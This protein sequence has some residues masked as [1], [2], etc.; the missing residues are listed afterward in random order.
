MKVLKSRLWQI[1]L[2]KAQS[3]LDEKRKQAISTGDR[4]AKIRTYNYPQDRVTDH[5]I[6]QSW[7]GIQRITDGDIAG[8]IEEVQVGL[9]KSD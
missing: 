7:F 6:K 4:S 8:I 5:R 9:A 1:E 2:D 3:L